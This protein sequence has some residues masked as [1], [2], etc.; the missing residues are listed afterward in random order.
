MVGPACAEHAP[1][2][3]GYFP[4][5][6][7]GPVISK[8]LS[9]APQRPEPSCRQNILRAS[10][11]AME[12]CTA[13]PKCAPLILTWRAQMKPTRRMPPK[14]LGLPLSEV[15]SLDDQDHQLGTASSRPGR[16]FELASVGEGPVDTLKDGSQLIFRARSE[17]NH[18]ALAFRGGDSPKRVFFQSWSQAAR[19][20][21]NHQARTVLWWNR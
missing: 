4:A 1:A 10:L 2:Q 13:S 3:R 11:T 17:A 20:V 7:R 14:R 15:V 5:G 21:T 16:S 12:G 19:S 6:Q 18:A 9:T 8:S